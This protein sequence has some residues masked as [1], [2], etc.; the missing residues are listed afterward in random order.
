PYSRLETVFETFRNILIRITEKYDTIG[1]VFQI[2]YIAIDLSPI[3]D[4]FFQG[5]I[6]IANANKKYFTVKTQTTKNCAYQS[7]YIGKKIN[8]I[9]YSSNQLSDNNLRITKILDG[10]YGRDD[11]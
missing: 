9:L 3:N 10:L 11:V 6:T 5:G 1:D 8:S 4:D 2:H 7:I